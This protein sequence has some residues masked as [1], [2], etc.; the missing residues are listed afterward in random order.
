[1]VPA[2]VDA[3]LNGHASATGRMILRAAMW[4]TIASRQAERI[5]SPRLALL[6]R[7]CTPI[8]HMSGGVAPRRHRFPCW[9][10]WR[11]LIIGADV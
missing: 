7:G 5:P 11:S 3:V 4:I 1:M 8:V 9:L 6:V 10:G 2:S